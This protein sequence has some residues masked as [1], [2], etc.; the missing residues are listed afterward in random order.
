MSYQMKRHLLK[1]T[2]Q[3]SYSIDNSVIDFVKCAQYLNIIRICTSLCM[4]T[5]WNYQF[6]SVYKHWL[7]MKRSFMMI[8]VGAIEFLC[9]QNMKIWTRLW[10]A[11][12]NSKGCCIQRYH[13]YK[14][15][16]R[17]LLVKCSM[18]HFLYRPWSL[19]LPVRTCA[20]SMRIGQTIVW[21]QI[22]MNRHRFPSH[23]FI[24]LGTCCFQ[25]IKL[26][27]QIFLAMNNLFFYILLTAHM[28][29]V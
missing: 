5:E 2:T 29:I 4:Y 14:G 17:K 16:R 12:K 6:E 26:N 23:V 11:W 8:L 10:K 28:K 25:T 9:G 1:D 18:T 19:S 3:K 27:S 24:V 21:F 13:V 15:G 22:T 20:E 7:C